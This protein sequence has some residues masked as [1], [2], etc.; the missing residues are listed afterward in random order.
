M[1]PR[2]LHNPA[3][4]YFANL[5]CYHFPSFIHLLPAPPDF[6]LKLTSEFPASRAL[7]LQLRIHGAHV[8]MHTPMCVFLLCI[9]RPSMFG[10]HVSP[11]QKSTSSHAFGLFKASLF[12]HP[13]PLQPDPLS[14]PPFI[15]FNTYCN[16]Q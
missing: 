4:A 10:L 11:L 9:T 15:S 16:L 13:P 5:T 2:A 6:S 3:P 7:Y 14:W 1:T 8:S 12:C